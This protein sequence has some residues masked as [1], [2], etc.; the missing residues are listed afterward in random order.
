MPFT[1]SPIHQ[2]IIRTDFLSTPPTKR[3]NK[4]VQKKYISQLDKKFELKPR[5][6]FPT[7]RKGISHSHVMK[8]V[9]TTFNKQEYESLLSPAKQRVTNQLRSQ[10]SEETLNVQLKELERYEQ[11]KENELAARALY[12]KDNKK[13]DAQ[14]KQEYKDKLV[15][16]SIEKKEKATKKETHNQERNDQQLAILLQNNYKKT[17]K[18]TEIKQQKKATAKIPQQQLGYGYETLPQELRNTMLQD[19]EMLNLFNSPGITFSS[20]EKNSSTIFDE[21]EHKSSQSQLTNTNARFSIKLFT[22]FLCFTAKEKKTQ[23]H[24]QDL[25]PRKSLDSRYSESPTIYS[26]QVD[27]LT[28]SNFVQWAEKHLNIGLSLKDVDMHNH[29]ETKVFRQSINR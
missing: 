20:H 4:P 12:E 10:V 29:F 13:K 16:L 23:L 2:A 28:P 15:A 7:K 26:P 3:K 24:P 17:R 9:T 8:V 5:N 19:E 27:L 22:R 1:F 11:E 25:T 21:R 14:L 18:D 6:L